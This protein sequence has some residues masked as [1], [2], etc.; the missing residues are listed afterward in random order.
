MAVLDQGLFAGAHF[1]LNVLLARWL[2]PE[3]YGAFA[4]SYSIF[5]FV[6]AVHTALITEP[7]MVFGSGK[8]RENAS[9]Y[10][11]SLLGGHAAL[12]VAGAMVLAVIAAACAGIYS[13]EVRRTLFTLSV[14]LFPLLLLWVTRRAFY[15]DFRPGWA[16]VGGVIY[17][18]LLVTFA[19][20]L[21]RAGLLS[22]ATGVLSMA[23]A[24]LLAVGLHLG[25]LRP[26]W[27]AGGRGLLLEVF[28]EH[29]R[30]GRWALGSAFVSWFP[31]NIYYLALPLW[32]GLE[33]AGSL[34]ALMNLAN[35]LLH[36][37][38]A[39]S[40]LLFPVLV[41][42][43]QKGRR[44]LMARA[45]WRFFWLFAFGSAAYLGP[46]WLFQREVFEI[47]YGGKYAADSGWPLLLAGAL[48]VG[49]AGTVVLGN[50]LRACERPD[51]VFWSYL[52]ASPL[53][54]GM[55]L[56]LSARF[57]LS[58]ALA[59]MLAAHALTALAMMVNL[60]RLPSGEGVAQA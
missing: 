27:A 53:A 9:S 16:V 54:V 31:M 6:A 35:P 47:L 13:P 32:R 4:L 26:S 40:L 23:G 42:H 18:L 20:G 11:G 22:S 49:C 14:C 29:W 41:R 37:I 38:T 7:M 25:R 5:L 36:S 3:S 56:A 15:F 55:G 33:E 10:L 12:T 19:G 59:G 21:Y 17:F 8:Y 34:R 48:P 51:G 57:G 2:S 60:R 44:D 46:L 45:G 1:A 52:V 30:Y 50:I 43:Q 28:R 58:G 39:I 24:S